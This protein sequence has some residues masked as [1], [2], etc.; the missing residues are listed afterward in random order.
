M[1]P[2]FRF[3]LVLRV[4]S[5]IGQARVCLPLHAQT[6]YVKGTGKVHSTFLVIDCMHFCVHVHKF[7]QRLVCRSRYSAGGSPPVQM[8]AHMHADID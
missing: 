4:T 3:P 6:A 8:C 2:L 5:R 1:H 7:R